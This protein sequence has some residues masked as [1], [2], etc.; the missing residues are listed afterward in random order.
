MGT[1]N[2]P[3]ICHTA[4]DKPIDPQRESSCARAKSLVHC[5]SDL[6][7]IY[8][9]PQYNLHMLGVR[10]NFACRMCDHCDLQRG[11][12]ALLK[13]TLRSAIMAVTSKSNTRER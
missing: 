2:I 13:V 1:S 7:C 8:R 10:G 4:H 12:A 9:L 6:L 3:G 11:A 5:Q